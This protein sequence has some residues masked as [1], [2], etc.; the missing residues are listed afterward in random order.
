M[1]KF[2]KLKNHKSILPITV[3]YLGTLNYIYRVDV[4]ISNLTLACEN[5]NPLLL[6]NQ[7]L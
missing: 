2:P 3:L 6:C 4:V 5:E 7:W 1:V